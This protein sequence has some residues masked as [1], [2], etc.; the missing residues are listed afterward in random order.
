MSRFFP[1]NFIVLF[2]ILV[3][4]STLSTSCLAQ[5]YGMMPYMGDDDMSEWRES[6]QYM[7]PG[8]GRMNRRQSMMPMNMMGPMMMPGQMMGMGSMMNSL[9]R[10]DLTAS[11]RKKIRQLTRNQRK[12]HLELMSQSMD[13]SDKLN[14]LY[15]EDELDPTKIGEVYGEIFT[16]RRQMIEQHI[17]LRNDILKVLNKEQLE[18]F[19]KSDDYYDRHYMAQ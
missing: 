16:I 2:F 3:A 17:K 4:T 19:K 9:M 15:L 8:Y 13:K 14:D 10:L 12:Q 1:L 11:Q 5:P 6:R 7:G 18:K